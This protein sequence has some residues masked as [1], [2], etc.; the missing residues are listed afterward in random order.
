MTKKAANSNSLMTASVP[1]D[2]QGSIGRR[3]EGIMDGD[4]FAAQLNHQIVCLRGPQHFE[5]RCIIHR[6]GWLT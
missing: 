5:D 6:K 2:L 4:F 3:L 1:I